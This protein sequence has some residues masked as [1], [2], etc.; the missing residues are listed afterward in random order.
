MAGIDAEHI[1]LAGAPQ[2]HLDIAEAN[3]DRSLHS[4]V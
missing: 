4:G 1:A 2:R 3:L